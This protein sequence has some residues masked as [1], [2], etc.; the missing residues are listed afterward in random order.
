M[1]KDKKKKKVRQPLAIK[2]RPRLLDQV[3]GQEGAVNSIRGFLKSKVIPHSILISG[4]YGSGKTTL[5]RLI[6]LYLNCEDPDKKNEPCQKCSS[7]IAMKDV[8]AG[9][10]DHPDVAELDAATKRGIDDMRD[11]QRIAELSHTY[12]HRCIILDECQELTPQAWKAML[13]TL[14]HSP[15][16]TVFI[17]CTTDP[18]KL[19]P[20]IISRSQRLN[21]VK[22]ETQALAS[23]L[24]KIAAKE[25][26]ELKK[27]ARLQLVELSGNHPRDALQLLEVVVN[28]VAL[29]KKPPKDLQKHF[30]KIF[31]QAEVY[32]T[33]VAVQKWWSSIFAAKY[34][35]SLK[36][37]DS[38]DNH[39]FFTSQAIL[40]FRNIVRQ[41]VDPGLVDRQKFWAL[42]QVKFPAAKVGRNHIQ[43][44]S[45]M[46]EK[47]LIAEA[48]VKGFQHDALAVLDHLTLDLVGI[49]KPWLGDK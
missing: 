2:Y 38:A 23:L 36:A 7:C 40:V 10:G 9:V 4:P 3:V 24:K 28:Y 13:K 41:W 1:K 6:C 47:L 43:E 27:K 42:K 22:V 20:T 30:P 35:D 37:I 29:Q 33:Y 17:L 8:I 44:A 48:R 25:G 31:A 46:M 18:E 16:S 15:G 14:E 21:L 34:G 32:K 5:A 39:V 49:T 19:P 12:N 45:L 11:L 26:I